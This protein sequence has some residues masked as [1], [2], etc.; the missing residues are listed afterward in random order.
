MRD[1]AL[2]FLS[3]EDGATAVE[4]GLILALMTVVLLSA[5]SA[6]SDSTQGVFNRVMT[7]ITNAISGA[8]G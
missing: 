2:R 8:V 1:L 6:F 5:L 3:D 4:Y 7:T